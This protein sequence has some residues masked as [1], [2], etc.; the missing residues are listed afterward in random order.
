VIQLEAFANRR[1]GRNNVL[2]PPQ[3]F[4][5]RSLEWRPVRFLIEPIGLPLLRFD[6][7]E[8]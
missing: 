1:I 8:S 3:F 7:A 6:R 2:V 4:L 5:F